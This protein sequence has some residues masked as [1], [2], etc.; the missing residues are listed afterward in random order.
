MRI[1]ITAGGFR[2]L[3]VLWSERGPLAT[4]YVDDSGPLALWRSC[5]V[6]VRGHPVEGGHFFPEEAPGETAGELDR[7]FDWTEEER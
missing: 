2:P 7:F 3:L 5:A 4:W 6:D 1:G